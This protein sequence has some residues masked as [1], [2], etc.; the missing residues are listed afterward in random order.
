[1]LTVH[2]M[3]ASLLLVGL[4][5]IQGALMESQIA[6]VGT[7]NFRSV[8]EFSIFAVV[9]CCVP[10]GGQ[11]GSAKSNS[12]AT[13]LLVLGQPPDGGNTCFHRIVF[14]PDGKSLLSLRDDCVLRL[15]QLTTR[16]E[17]RHVQLGP[18]WEAAFSRNSG[19]VATLNRTDLLT[20]YDTA[21]GREIRRLRCKDSDNLALSADGRQLACT[22]EERSVT[23]WELASGR[24]LRTLVQRPTEDWTIRDRITTLDFSSDGKR[25]AVAFSNGVVTVWQLDSGKQV[26]SRDIYFTRTRPGGRSSMLNPGRQHV[27]MAHATTLNSMIPVLTFIQTWD[28]GIAPCKVSFSPDGRRLAWIGGEFDK[29][30]L[31]DASSGTALARLIPG[32][33]LA[34]NS[35]GQRLAIATPRDESVTVQLG[36]DGKRHVVPRQDKGGKLSVWDLAQN[37]E[38]C[39]IAA[40]FENR[41]MDLSFSPDGCRVATAH[42]DGTIKVWDVSVTR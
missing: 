12:K 9:L 29:V 31:L 33:Y 3:G 39:C 4:T 13:P 19:R 6:T 28:M 14:S 16:K 42:R 32:Q 25:L 8:V 27:A 10:A 18:A 1:M 40:E 15:W 36:A 5:L 22:Q 21:S 26:F 34:F 2:F 35:D 38:V 23:I 7:S 41:L 37:R 20:I 30:R 17:V 11:E 24:E